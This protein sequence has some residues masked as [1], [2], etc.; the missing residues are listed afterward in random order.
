MDINEIWHVSVDHGSVVSRQI[1]PG[2]MNGYG[3][4]SPQNVKIGQNWDIS[5]V[6]LPYMGDTIHW[7]RW[8]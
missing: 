5:A 6:F 7:S 2:S 1:W 8:N 4:K 3:H